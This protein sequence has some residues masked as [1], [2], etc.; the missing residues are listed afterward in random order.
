MIIGRFCI[1]I[2]ILR[3]SR[4]GDCENRFIISQTVEWT[5]DA[6]LPDTFKPIGPT[7]DNAVI[8]YI[9]YWKFWKSILRIKNFTRKDDK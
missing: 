9:S 8:A 5:L 4:I 6:D 7:N 1:N 3:C 2:A